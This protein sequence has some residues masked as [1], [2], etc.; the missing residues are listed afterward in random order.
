MYDLK[1]Y[2]DNGK[3]PL[4][5][6]GII[7]EECSCGGHFLLNEAMTQLRCSNPICPYHMAQKMD[8][9]LKQLKAKDIGPSTCET[10][11]ME[12]GLVHHTQVLELGIYDMPSRNQD[13]IKEKYYNEI[14]KTK[15]L[16]ISE[17]A[18]LLRAPDMQTRCDDI[19]HGY[20][21][22]D[23]FYKDFN[24][25]E[26]FISERTGLSKGILTARFTN[27]LTNYEYILRG[28]CKLYHAKHWS[29]V[30]LEM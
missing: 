24:Y 17:I 9:M 23:E 3:V 27:S 25:S 30:W 14:H 13:Y 28:L 26:D 22:I 2:Y 21:D 12:N 18:K 11:I 19:F 1:Y 6:K 16:P 29:F 7:P 10:I 20:N 4:E 8:A 15:K 5:F